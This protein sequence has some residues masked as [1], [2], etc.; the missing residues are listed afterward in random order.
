MGAQG[1]WGLH[2]G[3]GYAVLC[4]GQAHTQ[5]LRICSSQYLI[6]D[7]EVPFSF[8]LLHHAGFLQQIWQRI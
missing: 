4:R 3:W 8:K 6:E 2:G 7:V 1:L 5:Q